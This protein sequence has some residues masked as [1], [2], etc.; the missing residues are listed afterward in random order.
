MIYKKFQDLSLSALGFGT[1]RLPVLPDGTPDQETVNRMVDYALENGV[2]YFDTAA[3]YH[4]GQ[5]E[6]VTGRALARHPRSSWML[7]DKYPGHQHSEVFTPQA[8]FEKQLRKCGVDYFDFYLYHNVCENSLDDYMNP[9]WGMLEY[10]VR[11]REAGRI[12]H[13]GLS[14]HAKPDVLESI[15]D[16]PYGQVIEFCQIQ[17]NYLDWTLQDA[18]RKLELLRERGIPVWVMEPVRGGFLAKLPPAEMARLEALRPGESAASWGFRW[19]QGI[20]EVGMVL[21]GMSNM[22]QMQDN[23]RTF[24]SGAPL[25]DSE[26]SLLEDIATRLHSGEPCTACRYC[27]DGCPQG[28]DIPS[29]ISYYNDLSLQFSFTP[30]MQ[31]EALPEDKRPSACLGCGACAAICPQGIQIPDVLSRLC[32]LFD[33]APKWKDICVERNKLDATEKL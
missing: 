20:P 11:E 18:A 31:I 4:G 15:L 12:R 32:G 23:I 9:R 7:A 8:T 3:P 16:G 14:T 1:M 33:K 10:F 2:N 26:R 30:V 28:L 19:L 21:S 17:L 6:I 22:E 25:S 5:S 27:C 29:L 13:L 24:S